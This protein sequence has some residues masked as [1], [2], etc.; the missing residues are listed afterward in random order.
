MNEF[1]CPK[2]LVDCGF[3]FERNS[4]RI[5]CYSCH[6]NLSY[7]KHYTKLHQLHQM[8]SRN[9]LFLQGKDVSIK[10]PTM[11]TTMQ[12]VGWPT[13]LDLNDLK[14]TPPYNYINEKTLASPPL[15]TT[16]HKTRGISLKAF[17]CPMR[18]PSNGCDRTVLDVEYYFK[19]LRSE[20]VRKQTFNIDGYRFP[21]SDEYIVKL[22]KLGF[23]YTLSNGAIQCHRCRHVLNGKHSMNEIQKYHRELS[24]NCDF[25]IQ[26]DTQPI[27][28]AL[29]VT[30]QNEE[31]LSADTRCVACWVVKKTYLC[32]P[33]N[34]LTICSICYTTN[35]P[36]NCPICRRENIIYRKIFV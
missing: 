11:L 7:S 2:Y 29:K 8:W 20:T 17:Y 14:K 13:P 21:Y 32:E 3:Y 36:K 18:V 22:A 24:P 4:N 33:C 25:E 12:C 10:T 1:S 23:F 15:T 27:S 31:Q 26:L 28:S 35:R 16:F 6:F 5:Y 19:M 34:H 30:A 9:C